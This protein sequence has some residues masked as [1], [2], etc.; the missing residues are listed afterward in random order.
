MSDAFDW[1]QPS[2]LWTTDESEIANGRFFQPALFGYAG[3]DFME[4][5]L[6]AAGKSRGAILNEARLPGAGLAEAPMIRLYQPAHGR[7][8]LICGSL[9]CREAGFPDRDVRAG[10]DEKV[11]FLLRKTHGAT[12]YA[13][14]PDGPGKGSWKILGDPRRP[15][16]SEQ[17]LP[18]SRVMA[19]NNRPLYMGYL[20][21]S[22]GDSYRI[23]ET[24]LNL[25]AEEKK[26]IEDPRIEELGSRFTAIVAGG[27]AAVNIITDASAARKV[28]VYALLD[29]YDYLNDYLPD[30][31][32]AVKSGASSPTFVAPKATEKAALYTFLR[33]AARPGGKHLSDLLRQTAT[34]ENTLNGLGEAALPPAYSDAAY[35][36]KATP[37]SDADANSL[38]AAVGNALDAAQRTFP[39]GKFTA[40]AEAR[41]HVR[42][43]YERPFCPPDLRYWVSR[44]S[45]K[46]TIAPFFDADAPARPVKITLPTDISPAALRKMNKNV[47]F[48]MSNAMRQNMKRVMGNEKFPLTLGGGDNLDIAFICSF[49]FQIIFIVAFF[50]L[51]MFV[52]IL[53]IVFWW[54]AFFRICLPLPKKLLPK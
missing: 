6:A 4:Q 52:F 3:D 35:D 23:A 32:Q 5:F 28:S 50:L 31:A 47:S 13:W 15:E 49:S 11:Y 41:Y 53:N 12:E 22:G 42:L 33:N 45:V 30:V 54:M 8:Y 39:V 14:I 48:Q 37:I 43:V 17:R 36:F 19:G 20:P 29:L 51:L 18:L 46:F 27:G 16:E 24:D 25:S 1:L 9:C 10:E 40:E 38:K 44:P 7:F 21:V 34:E 26:G 2:L